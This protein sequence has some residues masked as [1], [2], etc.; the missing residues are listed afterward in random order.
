MVKLRWTKRAAQDFEDICEF[1]AGSSEHYARLFAERVM[2]I[3][4]FLPKHPRQ[5]AM[6]P[7][8]GRDDLRERLFHNYR[9]VYRIH[10]TAVEV[11]TITHGARRFP[12]DLLDPPDY[13]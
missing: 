7:E 12:A 2:A 13:A 9:I 11:V 10:Q 5:G 3:V 1:L 4:E 6:V 8:Y